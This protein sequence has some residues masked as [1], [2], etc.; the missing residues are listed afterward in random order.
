[1]RNFKETEWRKEYNEGL[2]DND[3]LQDY[4]AYDL[5]DRI[6]RAKIQGCFPPESCKSLKCLIPIPRTHFL[7][8]TMGVNKLARLPQVLTV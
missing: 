3:N 4:I 8:V 7:N 5:Q 1:M 6:T 2:Q